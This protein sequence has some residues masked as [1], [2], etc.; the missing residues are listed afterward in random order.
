M[1]A[2]VLC[3][4]IIPC[5]SIQ[6]SMHESPQNLAEPSL[7]IH[8]SIA[9]VS[10]D[11]SSNHRNLWRRRPHKTSSNKAKIFCRNPWW[12]FSFPEPRSQSFMNNNPCHTNPGS[13]GKSKHMSNHSNSCANLSLLHTEPHYLLSTRYFTKSYASPENCEKRPMAPIMLP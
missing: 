9:R 12:P 8:E 5:L 7:F 1:Q 3:R 11:R 2:V 4:M 6:E 10:V 13:L